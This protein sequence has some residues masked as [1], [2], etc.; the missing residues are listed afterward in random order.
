MYEIRSAGKGMLVRLLQPVDMPGMGVG[1]FLATRADAIAALR[2]IFHVVYNE[3]EGA[4]CCV[5]VNSSAL[6][7]NVPPVVSQW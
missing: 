5:T 3:G 1:S 4:L 6:S 2:S 7:S